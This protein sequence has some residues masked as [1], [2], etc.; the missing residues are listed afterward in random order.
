[1]INTS[2]HNLRRASES[3]RQSY[4]NRNRRSRATYLAPAIGLEPITCRLTEGLSRPGAPGAVSSVT[5]SCLH[6]GFPELTRPC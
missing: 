5:L 3:L 4:V 6:K 1:M 2:Q